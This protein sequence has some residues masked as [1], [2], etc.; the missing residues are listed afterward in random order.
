MPDH[1][2]LRSRVGNA[3]DLRQGL[4]Q[5]IGDDAG[6]VPRRRFAY[7]AHAIQFRGGGLVTLEQQGF[8]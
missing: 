3:G 1:G 4:D 2:P 8:G 7:A 6:L 5:R